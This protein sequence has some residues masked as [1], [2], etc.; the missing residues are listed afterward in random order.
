MLLLLPIFVDNKLS[1]KQLLVKMISKTPG[2][3]KGNLQHAWGQ[4]MCIFQM[5]QA[6]RII[7]R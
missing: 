6:D 5:L 3:M 2:L 4:E 1:N 7:N